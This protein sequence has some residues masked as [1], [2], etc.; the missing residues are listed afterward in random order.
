MTPRRIHVEYVHP[1]IP[2]RAFDFCATYDDY[3]GEPDDPVGYGPT[4]Y[5][6]I[7]SLLEEED[8]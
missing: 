3:S 7:L 2:V 4:R 1:P 8:Q 6:A 5:D